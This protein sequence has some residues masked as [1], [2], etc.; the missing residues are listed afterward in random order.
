MNIKPLFLSIS[1]FDTGGSP[2]D[3]SPISFLNIG[4]VCMIMRVII[5]RMFVHYYDYYDQLFLIF[6][7]G[8]MYILLR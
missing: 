6:V 1:D 5:V 4:T 8:W 7:V 2:L 3:S